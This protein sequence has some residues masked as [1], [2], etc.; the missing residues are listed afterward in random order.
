M[1][2]VQSVSKNSVQLKEDFWHTRWGILLKRLGFLV[3]SSGISGAVALVAD[4]PLLFGGLTPA[5]YTLLTFIKDTLDPQIPNN[6]SE[7]I[8]VE[9]A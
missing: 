1:A 8:K 2:E 4:N 5:V 3:L 9:K 7:T 6:T